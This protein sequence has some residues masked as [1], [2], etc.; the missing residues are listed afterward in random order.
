MRKIIKIL[1][2]MCPKQ[3]NLNEM[4]LSIKKFNVFNPKCEHIGLISIICKL[5]ITK[6]ENK[7]N[8]QIITNQ[9][10]STM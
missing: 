5:A 8:S 4:S 6:L 3:Y 2:I 7:E 10:S 1:Q 9:A